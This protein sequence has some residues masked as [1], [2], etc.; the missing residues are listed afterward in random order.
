MNLTCWHFNDKLITEGVIVRHQRHVS[1]LRYPFP[2]PDY[3]AARFACWFFFPFPLNAEPGPRLF[4]CTRDQGDCVDPVYRV[5]QKFF[6]LIHK[7]VMQYD[8]TWKENSLNKSCVFQSSLIFHTLCAIFWLEYSIFTLSGQ[9]CACESKFSRHIFF[10]YFAPRIARTPPLF[11][12]EYH[13][14]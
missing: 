9:R 8:W 5:S 3:L 14:R 11:F 2:S 1:G 13:E 10:L 4:R 12:G 6:P 7:S